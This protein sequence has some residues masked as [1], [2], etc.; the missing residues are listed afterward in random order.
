MAGLHLNQLSALGVKGPEIDMMRAAWLTQEH[1]LDEAAR[2]LK[3]LVHGNASAAVERLRI[4]LAI[5]NREQ[6]ILDAREVHDHLQRRVQEGNSLSDHEYETWAA[7]E[8]LLGDSSAY[9]QL[10]REWLKHFPESIGARKNVVAISLQEFDE[11]LASPDANLRELA[12]RLRTAF[13]LSDATQNMKDRVA[14][15]YRQRGDR[16]ILTAMFE[17]LSKKP[18]LP[19]SL[20]ET[21]G[22]AAAISSE[23]DAAEYYLKQATSTDPRNAIAWNNLSCALLQKP[24]PPLESALQAAQKAC[25]LTPDDFRFRETRGEILVKLG[26]WREAIDDLEFALN[27]LPDNPAIHRSLGKAYEAVGNKELAAVHLQYSD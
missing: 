20:A 4:N 26:R 12:G 10:T 3:P 15:L 1:K 2:L 5:N 19:S 18:D 9:R 24:T 7:A 23:W 6:A 17:E 11:I 16:P 8:Q 21:L 14:L 25:E 22:T 27:G 13:T